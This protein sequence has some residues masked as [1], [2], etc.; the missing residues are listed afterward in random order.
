MY[1][2]YDV[3]LIEIF[4]YMYT[5]GHERKLNTVRGHFICNI[6]AVRHYSVYYY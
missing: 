4:C 1:V 3:T 2:N 6:Y 5:G